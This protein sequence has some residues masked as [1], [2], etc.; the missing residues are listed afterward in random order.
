MKITK[1]LFIIL[2]IIFEIIFPLVNPLIWFFSQSNEINLT[3]TEYYKNLYVPFYFNETHGFDFSFYNIITSFSMLKID[4]IFYGV[5]SP[6]FFAIGLAKFK[7]KGSIRMLLFLVLFNLL[8]SPFN[9]IQFFFIGIKHPLHFVFTIFSFV[10]NILLILFM[11]K[12]IVF[13]SLIDGDSINSVSNG[14]RVINFLLDRVLIFYFFLNLIIRIRSLNYENQDLM[15]SLDTENVIGLIFLMIALL[16]YLFSEGFFQLT[17]GKIFTKTIV[18]DTENNPISFSKAFKRT[19]CRFIPFE[20][21]S[22]IFSKEGWHDSL[23]Y[24]YVVNCEFDGGKEI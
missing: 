14:K 9:F 10:V 20:S 4:S 24:T 3:L 23:T 11:K 7:N 8:A 19:L 22:F 2:I 15:F 13:V 1:Q 5:L 17:L 6:I 12:K 18:V 21:L 16:Y